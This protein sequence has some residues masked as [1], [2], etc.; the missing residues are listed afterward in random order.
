MADNYGGSAV[1]G[2]QA[3]TMTVE[4]NFLWGNIDIVLRKPIKLKSTTI[5]SGNSP[6]TDLR[7][8][9]ALGRVTATGLHKDYDPTATDGSEIFQGFLMS[10][11]NMLDSAGTASERVPVG[12]MVVGN[13]GIKV[14]NVYGLDAIARRQAVGRF[15]F[16]DDL[17]GLGSAFRLVAAKTADY[18]VVNDTDNNK[19]FTNQGAGG[20]VNFTLPA[21]LKRGQ[22]WLF[23]CEAGQT[24]T[25]TAP[26]GKLVAFNNAG[27]TSIALSTSSEKIG[28]S[29]EIIV[30]ADATKYLAI[31]NLN[32]TQ[33]EVIA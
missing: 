6:T 8:G 9:L 30:N 5:D 23:Y 1:P 20:A 22:R 3:E 29:I 12:G 14:N 15:Y 19:V 2:F 7:A 18:T 32:E 24:I 21:T 16:D 10:N 33:T 4:N 11:T 17:P 28:G 31:Y 27:A 25:I 26:S 13:A